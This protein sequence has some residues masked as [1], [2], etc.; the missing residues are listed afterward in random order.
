MVG[1]MLVGEGPHGRRQLT[2]ENGA[3]EESSGEQL[4]DNCRSFSL[5]PW[6]DSNIRKP[7]DVS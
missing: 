4:S 5:S 6:L 3:R 7:A 2:S 1:I